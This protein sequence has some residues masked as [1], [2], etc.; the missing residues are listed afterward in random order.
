MNRNEFENWMKGKVEEEPYL[1]SEDMW[2]KLA[3]ELQAP[4]PAKKTLLF[5]PFL[6]IAASVVL[7]LSLGTAAVFYLKNDKDP[8]A[9]QHNLA[10]N[11]MDIPEQTPA[12]NKEANTMSPGHIAHNPAQ[13]A[14]NKSTPGTKEQTK[15]AIT[16]ADTNASRIADHRPEVY[17]ESA[18]EVPVIADKRDKNNN[19]DIQAPAYS[20]YTNGYDRHE[21]EGKGIDVGVAANVGK[22]NLGNNMGYQ[23]GVVGRKEISKRIFVEATLAMASTNVSY[24][25]Q[26]NFQNVNISNDGAEFSASPGSTT[27][28]NANYAR[29]IISVGFNP[30]LGIKVS[31][32]L[33]ISGG[34]AV[35]RNINPDLA[36]TNKSEIESAALQYNIIS[37]DE[38][39]SQWDL[40]LTGNADYKITRQLSVNANYRQGLSNYLHYNNKYQKNSGFNFGLKYIFGN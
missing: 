6:K 24:S 12:Q 25:Q 11:N 33:S 10:R 8:A 9:I 26:H 37:T 20:P 14:K 35:Y 3:G 28:I 39:V 27:N 16:M 30:S 21:K 32:N 38:K 40:G 29:N 5:V 31:R 4:P 2:N 18:K 34:G 19:H 7:L 36:L 17:K 13:I 23:I 22:T 1:P 15:I